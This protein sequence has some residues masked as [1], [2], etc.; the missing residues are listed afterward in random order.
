[1][2]RFTV[3]HPPPHGL[4]TFRAHHTARTFD[5]GSGTR[6]VLQAAPASPDGA[7]APADGAAEGVVLP[8]REVAQY[9]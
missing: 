8:D 6:A 2:H 9:P 3:P 1:M 5:A 4:A 7:G